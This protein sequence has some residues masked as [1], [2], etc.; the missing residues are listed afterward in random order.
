MCVSFIL[1]NGRLVTAWVTC[2]VLLFTNLHC[3]PTEKCLPENAL[4]TP[5][6]HPWESSVDMRISAFFQCGAFRFVT[7]L[8][9]NK[10]FY[11]LICHMYSER[12]VVLVYHWSLNGVSHWAVLWCSKGWCR[13]LSQPNW[14]SLLGFLPNPTNGSSEP[15]IIPVSVALSD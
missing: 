11:H 2:Y 4:Q 13:T 7:N 3:C 6:K 8:K 10:S 9:K 1:S 5:Q 15:E 14:W 12:P